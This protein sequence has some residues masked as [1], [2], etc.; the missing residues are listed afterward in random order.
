MGGGEQVR[1][2]GPRVPEEVPVAARLV[3]PGIAPVDGGQNESHRSNRHVLVARGDGERSAIVSITQASQDEVA[4]REMVDAPLE[5]GDIGGHHVDL[6]LVEGARRGGGAEI[7]RAAA[8]IRLP[9]GHPGREEKERGEPLDAQGPV[10]RGLARNGGE[11]IFR[12]HGE[13][14][15]QRHHGQIR[16]DLEGLGFGVPVEAMAAR[17]DGLRRVHG[18]VVITPSGFRVPI[19]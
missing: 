16:I 2:H 1:Q 15:R 18:G 9:L 11:R 19:A 4:R 6:G 3:L 17:A 13:V 8:R 7:H 5:S 10:G 12:R 14:A